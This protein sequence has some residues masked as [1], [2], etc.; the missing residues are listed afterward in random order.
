MAQLADC[1][2]VLQDFMKLLEIGDRRQ[3]REFFKVSQIYYENGKQIDRWGAER[4]DDLIDVSE[5]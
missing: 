3:C 4:K 2:K 5:S 1:R